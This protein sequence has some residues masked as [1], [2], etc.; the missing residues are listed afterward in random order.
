MNRL[1][2]ESN[3]DGVADVGLKN[4]VTVG[5][6]VCRLADYENTGLTP[7][8]VLCLRS[9]LTEIMREMVGHA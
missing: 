4:G 6:A 7:E 9:R 1:T 2:Y 8:Q 5:D 3:I